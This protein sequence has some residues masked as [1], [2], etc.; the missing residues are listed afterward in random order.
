MID[1]RLVCHYLPIGP[2]DGRGTIEGLA[3][4][5]VVVYAVGDNRQ[6]SRSIALEDQLS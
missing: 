4:L 6:G 5:W 1:V 3:S 2:I